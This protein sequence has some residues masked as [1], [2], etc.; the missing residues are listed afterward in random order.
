MRKGKT[1]EEKRKEMLNQ[2]TR[3]NPSIANPTWNPNKSSLQFTVS[4]CNLNS[5]L[6]R[7]E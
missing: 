5:N 7:I 1:T 4:S 6:G 3:L 2:L